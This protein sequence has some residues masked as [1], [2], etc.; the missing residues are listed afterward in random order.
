M[1]EG[2]VERIAATPPRPAAPPPPAPGATPSALCWAV[3]A[4]VGKRADR[5]RAAAAATAAAL[6]CE[7][8]LITRVSLPWARL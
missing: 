6:E 4:S 2:V 8:R 1:A 7:A 3:P 5:A